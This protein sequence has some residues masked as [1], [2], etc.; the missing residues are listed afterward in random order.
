MKPSA[1]TINAL[2][3]TS[4]K[5]L[6]HLRPS[7]RK[8]GLSPGTPVHVGAR[9]DQEVTITVIRYDAEE[10]AVTR[11]VP[12]R[13]EECVIPRQDQ[14]IT[15]INIDGLH[16]VDL[17]ERL[18]ADFQVH[19]L[20][21]EDIL[22]TT[23]RPKVDHFDDYLFICLKMHALP[24]AGEFVGLDLEQISMVLGVNFLITFQEWR[25]PVFDQ[26]HKRLSENKGRIRKM[27]ADYLAYALTD[28]IIDNF[29][30][31]LE[32]IGEEIEEIEELLISDPKPETLHQIHLLKRKVLLLRKS[33]WPLR[34]VI[35]SLQR[36]EAPII[37]L[38]IDLYLR[39]LYDHTIHIIDTVE[40][41][42]D[43]IAGMLDIYL[44]S[45]SFRMNE[46]MK[47][48]TMFTA[49]FIPLT[50]IAGIYGMNFNT[51]RSPWNMPE[52]NWYLG[53]PLALGLM[54]TLGIG[55]VVYFKRKKWF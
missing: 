12:A 41:F 50:L 40:T 52:L 35:S 37:T 22:N 49:V 48:L 6:R 44:S 8:A 45:L 55:M 4:G 29:F 17:I 36:G 15:W 47:V 18:C 24:T 46:I 51:A 38:A 16:R 7:A 3:Q 31:T 1:A 43:V 23:Q 30:Q 9:I 21:L 2:G 39:D 53:Y 34:E 11:F 10:F 42:R 13:V 32:Q 28:A 54:T 20:V 19:P 33:V 25:T 5:M 14:G 26:V 27:G